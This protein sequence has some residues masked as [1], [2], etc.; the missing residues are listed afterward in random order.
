MIKITK[1]RE[2]AE[3]TTIRQTRGIDFETADKTALRLSLL[4]EQ[5]G[6]CGYCMRRVRYSVGIV[7]DTRIE[8]LKPRSLSVTEGK[9]EETM[10]YNNMILCCNGDIDKSG[11]YHCDVSKRETPIHF[12]PLDTLAMNTISYS[13]KTGVIMSSNAQFD[14]DINKVLNLNHPRLADN[15][16]SVIKALVRSMGKKTWR[17][18]EV[19]HKLDFYRNKT[20]NGNYQ[21]Y[22]GVAIW[23]LTKRLRL[24]E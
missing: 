16:L 5:G 18:S 4:A 1:G 23:F 14:D 17:K 7:T 20:A 2:P 3:W 21:E 10:D 22:C 6:I 19:V 9:P 15:R 13:S 11:R 8:H 12:T 24:F